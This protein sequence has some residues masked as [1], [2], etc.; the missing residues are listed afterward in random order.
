MKINTY[1]ARELSSKRT[2]IGLIIRDSNGSFVAA[3]SVTLDGIL[4][5]KLAEAIAVREAVKWASSRGGA[6]FIVESD[7]QLVIQDLNH[8]NFV[9]YFDL[10]A[11]DIYEVASIIPNISFRFLKRSANSVAHLLARWQYIEDIMPLKRDRNQ[12]RYTTSEP[13]TELR[14]VVPDPGRP[15]SIRS[16]LIRIHSLSRSDPNSLSGSSDLDCCCGGGAS[17]DH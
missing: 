11:H 7:S 3:K 15:Q 17:N 10:I 16:S 9:S 13:P 14:K 4:Q 5:V 2:G 6:A 12:L 8:H 1:A